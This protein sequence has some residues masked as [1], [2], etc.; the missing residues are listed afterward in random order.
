MLLQKNE[1]IP[2]RT[3]FDGFTQSELSEMGRCAQ[4]WNWRYNHRL[5]KAGM[6]QFPFIVGDVWHDAMEQFYATKGERVHVATLQFPEAAV[7]SVQ[8][9]IDRDYWNHVLPKMF[10]AYAS[11][12]RGDH[13]KW[14]I[15][16]IEEELDIEYRGFRLRGKI[17][18]T[19]DEPNGRFTLDHKTTSRLNKDIVA[20]WDFRFQF[21]FYLWLKSKAYP[22]EKFKGYYTNATKKPELRVKQTES[23]PEFAHRVFQD[24]VENPDKYFY[25]DAFPVSP[26]TLLHFQTTV[27]D[28]KLKKLEAVLDPT[29]PIDLAKAIIQDKNT[30]ECQHYNGPPCP[31][32]DLCRHGF[33][34]MKFLYRKKENKHDELEVE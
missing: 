28:H 9:I 23:V 21:L 30:D 33:Q 27:I 25:R 2:A 19:I 1:L 13:L 4:K 3:L 31:Y 32:L 15:I 22:K 20:G 16:S 18:L 12:Y 10:E 29:T 17:D 26:E 11:Y 34:K 7:P 14:K 24:M 8:D 5:E 6:I